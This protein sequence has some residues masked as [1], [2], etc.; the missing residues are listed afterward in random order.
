V[1]NGLLTGPSL[2]FLQPS[3]SV[4]PTP[5]G[6]PTNTAVPAAT[7]AAIGIPLP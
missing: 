5:W 1:L 3:H 7:L 6:S 2:P 4:V